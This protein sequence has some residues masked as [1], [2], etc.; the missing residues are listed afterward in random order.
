MKKLPECLLWNLEQVGAA[1]GLRVRTIQYMARDDRLPGFCKLN[2]RP[3]WQRIEIE[4]WI[5][6]GMP[7]RRRNLQED[8]IENSHLDDDSDSDIL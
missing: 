1:L 2:G 7:E 6:A 8:A 5:A 3:R 4:K